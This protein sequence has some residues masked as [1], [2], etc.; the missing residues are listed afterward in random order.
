ML[1]IHYSYADAP[2]L[3]RFAKSK[4]FIRGLS[5]PFRSGKSSA[6]TIEGPRLCKEQTPMPDGV[7]RTRL[8]VVRNTTPQL[9]DTT[10]KTFH[11]WFPPYAC[12]EWKPSTHTY[13]MRGFKGFDDCETEV[14]FRA[15]DRPDHVR[16]LLSLEVSHAW[17]NEGR[18]VPWAIIDA[19]QGRV[20][21][22]PSK[23]HGGCTRPALWLDTNMP[24]TDSEWYRF[25]EDGAFPPG[26]AE[27][28]KQPSG[29][30]PEAENLKYING[31][32]QYYENLA[33]GKSDEW[34][35]VYVKGEYGF[36]VDGQPVYPEYSDSIH[37]RDDLKTI[38]DEP[39]YRG[40]DFGL[41][42]S[43]VVAQVSPTGR[44]NVVDELCATRMGI[45]GFSDEALTHCAKYYPKRE[46]IDIG[47]PS[48]D[49]PA[50]TDERTCFQI[51]RSK[52]IQ[53]EGGRQDPT[54]RQES[55]RKPLKTFLGG[56]PAVY[57]FALHPRCKMLR[58]G[59]L[60]GYHYLRKHGSD[61]QLRSAAE[62]NQYSHPHDA[63]QYICA[64]IYGD[65]LTRPYAAE[66]KK[67]YDDGGYADT[68]RNPMTGY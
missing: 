45:D 47:D 29:L 41:T 30:S 6:C 26:F 28:F 4:A 68:T 17:V 7:R 34:I 5:G 14:M 52:N 1:N 37:C 18:E 24:D 55:V 62:K 9:N 15:L 22:F 53:I 12:G 21:Q 40:W 25:F 31:G 49:S 56:N 63:L 38:E 39:I 10:I 44:L 32:R 2:T 54:I 61:G 13:L 57:C 35:K 46:F 23:H 19:L 67:D 36:I 3:A 43:C 20:G 42:P 33:I 16:N 11:Q 27:L 51:L 59:F 48:G 58:K 64:E 65:S 50:E 8:L 66:Q 60:G